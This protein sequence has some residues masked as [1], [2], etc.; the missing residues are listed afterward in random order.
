MGS[1]IRYWCCT[2]TSGMLTPARRP[3]SRAH[4]PVQ[5]T[6]TSQSITPEVVS[7]PLTRPFSERTAVTV[8]PSTMAAPASRAPLASAWVISEGLA[9]PSVGRK[10]AP[11]TSLTSIIGH[12][13]LASPGVSRCISRPK[14]RAVVAW[15]CISVS[16]SSVQASRSPPF[17]FQPV[18]SPV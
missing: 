12:R 6:S 14:L 13:S 15:R 10:A 2:E 11:I 8:T 17:I 1:V 5:L 4:W 7:T 3:N 18:A 16:R 9:W